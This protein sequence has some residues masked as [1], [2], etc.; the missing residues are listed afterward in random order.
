MLWFTSDQHYFHD[1]IRFYSKR[2]FL[3]VEDMNEA[4]IKNWNAVVKPNDEVWDLG[5]FSFGD[6]EKTVSVLKRLNG[7]HNFVM[8]NHD[9]V[10][11][12]NKEELLKSGLL[13]SI[14]DYKE[15]K[16]ENKTLILFHFPIKSWNKKHH[17]SI[18]CFGH[19]HSSMPAFAKSV[20]VGIDNKEITSEYR[21][22]SFDE[23]VEFM[24]KREDIVVDHHDGTRA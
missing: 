7:R 16:Y 8:G 9:K 20:D 5:D 12:K 2:P 18:H 14:Q 1:K 6:Y 4:L 17:G 10:I 3:S 24:D 19:V 21:P 13:I 22:I 15:I 11:T 23:L